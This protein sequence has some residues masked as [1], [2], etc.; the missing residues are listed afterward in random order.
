ARASN[1]RFVESAL[2]G[3]NH[4]ALAE[5]RWRNVRIKSGW[6]PLRRFWP[7][8]EGPDISPIRTWSGDLAHS[9]HRPAGAPANLLVMV[10]RSPI[11]RRYPKTA[12]YLIQ[13]TGDLDALGAANAPPPPADTTPPIFKGVLEPDLHYVGFGITVEQAQQGDGYHLVLE[14][15]PAEPRFRTR[16]PFDETEPEHAVWIENRKN[17]TNG[18]DYAKATF[19]QRI[20]AVIKLGI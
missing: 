13:G 8:P 19:H 2:V 17:A 16:S 3:A 9:S 1:A 14:E 18:A 4:R 12:G 11:L 7:R 6:S 20:V 15:P 5:L 10:I